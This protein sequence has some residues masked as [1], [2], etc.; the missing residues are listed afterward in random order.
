M[1][2]K[3]KYARKQLQSNVKLCNLQCQIM[4][5]PNNPQKFKYNVKCLAIL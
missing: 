5:P 1:H 4:D 3:Q 2:T